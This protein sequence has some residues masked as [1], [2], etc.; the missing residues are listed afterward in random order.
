IT[1]AKLTVDGAKDGTTTRQPGTR[2]TFAETKFNSAV[3][4]NVAGR[5][6]RADNLLMTAKAASAPTAAPSAAEG[7]SSHTRNANKVDTNI[8]T[9]GTSVVAN[10]AWARSGG[11]V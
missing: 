5:N 7:L 10:P 4:K 8:E 1:T 2:S 11:V 9:S 6:T 3:A